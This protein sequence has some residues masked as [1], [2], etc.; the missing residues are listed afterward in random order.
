MRVRGARALSRTELP[1]GYRSWGLHAAVARHVYIWESQQT[2]SVSGCPVILV[3]VF[4]A[5]PNAKYILQ[6]HTGAGA[7]GALEPELRAFE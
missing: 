4:T 6:L 2:T 5:S 3:P 1:I 7:G